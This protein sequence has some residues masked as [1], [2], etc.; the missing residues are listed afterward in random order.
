V[1]EELDE[2]VRVTRLMAWVTAALM[3]LGVVVAGAMATGNDT[4]G[5]RAVSAA[6]GE[7]DLVDVPTTVT[8]MVVTTTVPPTTVVVPTTTP[9]PT[10]PP[11]TKAPR[12]TT[13]TTRA[14]TTPTA[15]GVM[16][17]IV[18]NSPSKVL[19]KVNGKSFT[20]EGGQKV[21]PVPVT[22]SADGNDIIEMRLAAEPTCGMGDADG[23]F[24]KPGSYLLTI[25]SSPGSCNP[26]TGPIASVRYRVTPA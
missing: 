21:G 19:L 2:P 11:T 24:P 12:P 16:L 13:T 22:R 8:T 14:T 20:V 10:A 18:N 3:V 26:P 25:E 17:T 15:A 23:Y 7:A 4:A 9:A 1:D 6:G 5:E